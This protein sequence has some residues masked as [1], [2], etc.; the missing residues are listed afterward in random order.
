MGLS[1]E[2]ELKSLV[3]ETSEETFIEVLSKLKGK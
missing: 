1:E 3:A 2:D